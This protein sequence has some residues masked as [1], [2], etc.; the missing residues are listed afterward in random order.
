MPTIGSLAVK[1]TA[2]GS[3]FASG[4]GSAVSSLEELGGTAL[5][6][7]AGMAGFSAAK[8]VFNFFADLGKGAIDG[9]VSLAKLARSLDDDTQAIGGLQ[10]GVK[11]LGYD[12][13]AVDRGL[14]T[15]ATTVNDAGRGAIVA[16]DLFS[17]L[18]L[19]IADLKNLAPSEQF[20]AV[21]ESISRMSNPAQKAALAVQTFGRDALELIPLLDKGAAGIDE[22]TKRAKEMG[23]APIKTDADR[24]EEVSLKFDTLNDKLKGIGVTIATTVAP[25]FEALLDAVNNFGTDTDTVGSTVITVLEGIGQGVAFVVDSWKVMENLTAIVKAGWVSMFAAF[26]RGME[27]MIDLA[28]QIPGVGGK[29]A[30]IQ[31]A[32]HA[33]SV[34]ATEAANNAMNEADEKLADRTSAMAKLHESFKDFRNRSAKGGSFDAVDKL[35][36]DKTGGGS[37]GLANK[38]IAFYQRGLEITKQFAGSYDV[39][40]EK[41]GELNAMLDAG[42]IKWDTYARAITAAVSELEKANQIGDTRLAGAL[43][44]GTSAAYSAV[45]KSQK[46]AD[47]RTKEDPAVRTARILDES[48]KI[49]AQQLEVARRTAEYLRNQNGVL[50]IK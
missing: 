8:G 21:A 46:E 39:A 13:S 5:A 34:M 30:D 42:A 47:M 25:V 18:G 44:A 35:A 32:A 7:S 24:I 3:D 23:L 10:Y 43:Q 11:R 50:D 1:L 49:Q 15:L 9:V 48:K 14:L 28:A 20:R 38:N 33:T 4:I 16:G 2:V 45:V 26:S 31:K 29:L 27:Q 22:F 17:R 6:V 41:L 36:Q 12:A 19:S 37:L 40:Q